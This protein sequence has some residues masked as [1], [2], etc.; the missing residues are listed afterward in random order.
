MST[1]DTLQN[2]LKVVLVDDHPAVRKNLRQLIEMKGPFE[3]VAE[4][5]NGEEAIACVEEH[6]PDLV[7]MDMNMP[8]MAGAEATEI[9]KGRHPHVKVLA[10]TAFA[11]MTHVSAMVKAGA[12]GYVLKGGTSQ[13][14]LG[15]LHAVAAGQATLDKEVTRGVMDDMAELYRKEQERSAA[16]EELDRMK[17]EFVAV[18]S[19]ELQ[20]PVTTIKGGALTLQSRWENMSDEIRNELLDSVA[21]SCDHLSLMISRLL[22]VSGIQRGRIGLRSKVFSLGRV[23]ESAL[24]HLAPKAE[25]RR[26]RLSLSPARATGDEQRLTEVAIALIENA[27]EFTTGTVDVTVE[28]TGDEARLTVVDEGPGMSPATVAQLVDTPFTQGDSSSTR[29]V[30]GLGL[31]LDIARQVLEAAGGLLEIETS[32]ETGSRFTMVL[33]AA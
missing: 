14:L 25:G 19:H 26:V 16:L 21:R 28:I 4:G 17:S 22:T 8:V 1:I 10:L 29:R 7:L 2:T 31:S 13:E 32:A 5:S 20:T 23:A 3:V 12:S 15:A 27:L 30:G 9:I 33:P 24:A 6:M 11:D 18:V